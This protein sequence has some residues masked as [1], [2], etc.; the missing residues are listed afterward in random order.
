MESVDQT[1]RDAE[2]RRIAAQRIKRRRD[3]LWHLVTYLVVNALMVFVWAIGPRASFWPMW[4]MVF[5]GIGLVFHAYYALGKQEVTEADVD[6]E[7]RR[8]SRSG[9]PSDQ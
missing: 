3:F 1:A 8:S 4:L 5:W 7:L 2:E 6:A 9:E